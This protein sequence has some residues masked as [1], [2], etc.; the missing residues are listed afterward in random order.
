MSG[1]RHRDERGS[2]L[3]EMM[4]IVP[5][6]MTLALGLFEVG[7]ML[8]NDVAIANA[9]RTTARVGSSAGNAP[10]GDFEM[11]SAFG[12]AIANVKSATI[13]YVVVYRVT[14]SNTTPT[15][16][17]IIS[18]SGGVSNQCNTYSAADIAAIVANPTSAKTSYGGSCSGSGKDT[19]WCPATRIIDQGSTNGPDFLG[20]AL[21]ITVPTY[22]NLFGVTK[23]FTDS[24]VM[25]LDPTGV[26]N[27]GSP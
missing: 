18:T 9:T 3:I 12:A 22:T 23:T 4:F 2:I 21:S 20:V 17:C 5:F 1:R 24:F 10:T 11:L 8:R 25:R 26:H 13:N 27:A 6:L 14:G 15:N 19:K 7:M 16:A